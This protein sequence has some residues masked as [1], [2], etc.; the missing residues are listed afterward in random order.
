MTWC[1]VLKIA[2]VKAKTI[3]TYFGEYLNKLIFSD[4]KKLYGPKNCP[5][6]VEDQEAAKEGNSGRVQSLRFIKS[7]NE[8]DDE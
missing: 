8:S 6:K 7:V 2:V 3:N 4:K 5:K 1:T